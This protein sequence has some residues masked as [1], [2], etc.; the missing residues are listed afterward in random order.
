M[1]DDTEDLAP[2]GDKKEYGQ[3]SNSIL[4]S[5]PFVSSADV[6]TAPTSSS[7]GIAIQVPA[8]VLAHLISSVDT[9]RNEMSQLQ[10]DMA[11]NEGALTSTIVNLQNEVAQLR[12]E[13]I[14]DKTKINSLET[15]LQSLQPKPKGRVFT[16]FPKLP[17]ELRLSI[18][19]K[20]LW[21]PQVIAV[22]Q[23][24]KERTAVT[25]SGE[26]ALVPLGPHSLLRQVSKEARNQALKID[27][28]YS[29]CNHSGTPGLF[30]N[31]EIDTI[32]VV[33]FD[34]R[35]TGSSEHHHPWV[36]LHKF[37]RIAL[38]TDAYKYQ[39]RRVSSDL[40]EVAWKALMF[41]TFLWQHGVLHLHI[42]FDRDQVTTHTDINLVPV[43]GSVYRPPHM[44][45]STPES[46]VR[47]CW[48]SWAETF[49]ED[50]IA[51]LDPWVNMMHITGM[52]R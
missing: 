33:D 35:S 12:Q 28:C 4:P 45:G 11:S 22:R 8:N 37:S 36:H 29:M 16:L 14:E 23:H 26:I 3:S 42:V 39:M 50:A 24:F 44:F 25:N 52:T 40:R 5:V 43:R 15:E 48:E 31:P 2:N 27:T 10:S 34:R 49:R 20:A 13:R 30:A 51:F 32:W 7:S 18:W 19:D 38:T 1:A 46:E 41:H 17:I 6:T 9:L 47:Y 21:T